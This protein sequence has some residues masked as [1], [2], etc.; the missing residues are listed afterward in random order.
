MSLNNRL[1]AGLIGLNLVLIAVMLGRDFSG[2]MRN[3]METSAFAAPTPAI[4]TAPASATTI[5]P[6]EPGSA[7]ARRTEIVAAAEKFSPCVVSIGASQ[8]GYLVNPYAGF[9][10]NFTLFPYEEK[11][12]YLGSGVIIDSDGLIVTN[13]HVVEKAKEVFVTLVD[14]REIPGEVLDADTALDVALIKVNAKNLPT[15]R[16]GDSNN[17]MVGE[18]VLA[19]GNPFGNV[20]GDPTPT[21][22]VGVVSA[23]KRSF[24]PNNEMRKVYLDMIQTDAAINPGNS[25]GALINASGEL[26]GINTFIMSR[27]G[28]AEGIGFAIPINRVKA[29]TDEIL[30]HGKIRSRLVDFQAQNLTERIAKNVGSRAKKGA[31]V[32]QITRGGPADTAGMKVGDVVI[33]VDG[34]EV[35]DA[36]DLLIYIFSQQVGAR[37][38]LDIDRGGIQIKVDYELVEPP[39]EDS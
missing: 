24:R 8:T 10:S 22:T 23:L 34:R 5:A 33:S 32:S 20:I 1:I 9:F 31:V 27:S 11:I 13:Y 28:G 19:M 25:G 35:R 36:N 14:G 26:V 30:K 15:A 17:L 3:P 7:A 29:V 12:P 2:K 38:R 18:W 4:S 39:K 21:V 6:G 16:L 37:S